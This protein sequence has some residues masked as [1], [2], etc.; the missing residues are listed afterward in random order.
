MFKYK[1]PFNT[2]T[3]YKTLLT[4]RVEYRALFIT[5]FEYETPSTTRVECWVQGTIYRMVIIDT[6]A[7]RAIA[8][9]RHPLPSKTQ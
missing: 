6:E 5:G 2:G 8:E 7:I 4:T 3:D 9:G 1:S